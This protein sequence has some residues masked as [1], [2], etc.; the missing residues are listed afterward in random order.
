LI[1]ENYFP[2][3]P[4]YKRALIHVNQNVFEW[5]NAPYLKPEIEKMAKAA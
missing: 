4:G 1:K 2:D 5:I 3:A